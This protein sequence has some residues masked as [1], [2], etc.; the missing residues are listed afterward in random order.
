MLVSEVSQCWCSWGKWHHPS[1]LFSD[2]RYHTPCCSGSLLRIVRAISMPC[3][4][5]LLCFS[6]GA[7]LGFKTLKGPSTGYLSML[8]LKPIVTRK[9]FHV[10]IVHGIYGV[11]LLKAGTLLHSLWICFCLL[12]MKGFFLAPAVFYPW[13]GNMLSSKSTPGRGIFSLSVPSDPYATL[14]TTGPAP[15]FSPEAGATDLLWRK[16][17]TSKTSEFEL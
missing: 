9:Q 11:A 12:L 7:W 4:T 10:Y 2:R 1:L 14:C 13:G 5:A 6:V 3:T 8:C 15:S 16:S 17:C